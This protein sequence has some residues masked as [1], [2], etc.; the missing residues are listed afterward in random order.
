MQNII[1]IIQLFRIAK[2]GNIQYCENAN[3]IVFKHL[4]PI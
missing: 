4:L 3:T 2:I 1:A